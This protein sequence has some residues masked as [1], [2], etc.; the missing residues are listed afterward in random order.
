M[1]PLK[2][3]VGAASAAVLL[4]FSLTACGGAPTDDSTKDFCDAFDSATDIFA[5]IDPEGDPADQAGKVTDGYKEF[6]DKLEETGT[7]ENISDDAREGF[8]IFVEELGDLDEDDVKKY[9]E[10][11]SEDIAE[12]SKDDEKKVNEFTDY[13]E[14][15]CGTPEQ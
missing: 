11:P 6:A 12:V 15:E 1:T 14:K 13:A 4:A 8:E 10:D 2:R 7:P 5:D 9:L 3:Y